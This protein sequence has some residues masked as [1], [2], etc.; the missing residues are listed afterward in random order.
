MDNSKPK[1]TTIQFPCH[2]HSVVIFVSFRF[3]IPCSAPASQSGSASQYFCANFYNMNNV[4]S[5]YGNH[6]FWLWGTASCQ[7]NYA[8]I[9]LF[10]P[11]YI[12][13]TIKNKTSKKFKSI[14]V[15]LT[16]YVMCS[17]PQ[18]CINVLILLEVRW[19][20]K[21]KITIDHWREFHYYSNNSEAASR[22]QIHSVEFKT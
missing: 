4:Y 22:K 15:S 11:L 1:P 6:H 3:S 13:Y 10:F 8:S 20:N 12:W 5:N 7:K 18:R 21:Q 17:Q 2:F 16:L 14:L 9:S 19:N